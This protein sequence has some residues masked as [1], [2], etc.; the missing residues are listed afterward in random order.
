[1]VAVCQSRSETPVVDSCGDRDP[2]L[3]PIRDKLNDGRRLDFE[4]GI[5]LFETPDLIGLGRIADECKRRKSGDAVYFVVNRHINYSNVCVLACRF[6][7][8][9]RKQRDPDA[10]RLTI[11]DILAQ[12]EPGIQ[13]LHIVGGHDPDLPLDWYVE[14]LRAVRAHAPGLQIKAFTAAEIDYFSRRWSRSVEEIL[15]QFKDA[16][17]SSLPGGGAEVFSERVRRLLFPGKVSAERWLDVHRLAHRA[18]IPSNA[19]LLYG[20]IETHAERVRHLL[21]LRELQDETGGFLAFIPLAYQVGQT[22]LVARAASAAD[23]LRMIAASRLL[24]D[25]VPHIKAYWVMLGEA[26]ASMALNFGADD[27]DGT[28]GRERI[29]HAAG[30]SSAAGLARDRIIRLIVDARRTPVQRDALYRVV[31]AD[32]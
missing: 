2:R 29:A 1:M 14:M 13:E 16:G 19:S 22:K 17:L 18:G 7:D 32:A 26:T 5:T 6:C 4:D 23:D 8:F 10:L 31:T 11:D 30:A 12:L 15:D 3:R 9:A 20:H 27:L 28:I 21:M 24:L 25:N